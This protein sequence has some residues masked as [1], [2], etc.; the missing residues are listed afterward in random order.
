MERMTTGWLLQDG[1][2]YYFRS[3]GGMYRSTFFKAPTGSALYYADENG[4][5]AVGKKQIDG[6][7]YYFKDWGG[8]YQNAFIKNGT[9]V[10]H[11]AADGKLTVAGCSRAVHITILMKP[12]SSILT[13]FLNMTTIH[14]V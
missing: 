5:M 13:A 2:W 10:C 6:D 7:W 1:T 3:W 9:S 8:M 14:I 11:A 12:E 4:K